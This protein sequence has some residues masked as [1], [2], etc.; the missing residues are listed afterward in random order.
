MDDLSGFV[1]DDELAVGPLSALGWRV[2]FVPWRARI[3]WD[4][5]DLVVMRTPWD[6]QDDPDAFLA[7]LEK[8]DT[9]RAVLENDL[10]LVRWNLRK[11]YLFDLEKRGAAI[12]PTVRGDDFRRERLAGLFERLRADEIILKPLIGANADRTYRVTPQA[13]DALIRTLEAEFR[14]REHLA[15]P[16]MRA[17]VDEGEFSLFFFAGE[18]SHTIL[19]TPKAGDFRVQEEHGGLIR[20]VAPDEKLTAR[21]ADVVKNLSPSPLYSRVDFV[22]TGDDDF[23]LMELELIEPALY[24][25]MDPRSA[26]HF[27]AALDTKFRG[28]RMSASLR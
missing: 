26:S 6:Y 11:S 17:I 7:V 18:Y 23:A 5:Y 12:V 20:P 10:E 15:Q 24:F 27:A 4:Q 14:A 22:R 1:S 8:I 2:D 13:G 21:A 19:K 25:R 9:S 3:E 28:G 16:F